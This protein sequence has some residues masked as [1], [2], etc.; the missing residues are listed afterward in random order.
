MNKTLKNILLGS[1]IFN[2]L[3][4]TVSLLIIYK[5]GGVSWVETKIAS[6]FNENVQKEDIY[7]LQRKDLFEKINYKADSILFIGD[8]ITDYCEW[9]DLTEKDNI[10]NM[11][12]AGDTTTGILNRLDVVFKVNP[13]KV[14][15]MVGINDLRKGEIVDE[16]INNYKTI[17]DSMREKLPTTTI[18][19]QSTLP[20]N[21]ELTS[22][23]EKT[24]VKSIIKLNN[25]IKSLENNS[26]IFY[27]DLFS[28]FS[29]GN[30]NEL[31][32]KFSKDGVHLNGDA[33][34]LWKDS[35]EK[36]VN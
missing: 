10:I 27:I 22:D 21:N 26:S 13:K 36:Y 31:N 8:S 15:I 7:Y 3:F 28:K 6:V 33:Y 25:G 16:V 4:I 9:D 24:D 12:I 20:L 32:E 14:F 34:L 1:I 23:I 29:V 30:D 5:Q 11:G 18:Y 2:C 35:I 17:V 19:I